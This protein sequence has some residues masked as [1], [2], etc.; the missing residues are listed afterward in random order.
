MDAARLL[1][2][3]E[4]EILGLLP[5]AS[6]VTLLT[7]VSDAADETLAV[8]KPQR[9]ERPLWD[10][11]DGTLCAR[12]YAAWVVDDRL[13]WGLVPPTVLRDGPAGV[14][15]VQ[16]YIEED[17]NFDVHD[18]VQTHPEELR[19]MAALDVVI[20]NADRKAGHLIADTSGKLWGVDHGVCF[21]D[22]PK[23]RTVIWTFEGEPIPE[24][25][26]AD[27]DRFARDGSWKEELGGLLDGIEI[28][29]LCSRVT[30]LLRTKRFPM[31]PAGRYH[32]PWPPC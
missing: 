18:V 32:V 2:S 16:L 17:E 11:P 24:A 3:G 19:K 20:N 27:L 31:P 10:F 15:A 25:L 7:K 14:G 1:R 28:D 13:G 30:T 21:H 22:E 6:N 29:A 8:Y 23:L 9:G 26:L 4:M 5:Y 12:E